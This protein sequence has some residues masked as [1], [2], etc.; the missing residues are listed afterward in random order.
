[1][2]A[3]LQNSGGFDDQLLEQIPTSRALTLATQPILDVS[4]N[5]RQ[6]AKHGGTSKRQKALHDRH[7][8]VET[9]ITG[10]AETFAK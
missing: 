6:G 4:H 7:R 9:S 5:N 1:M 2:E 3:A 10:V 8:S